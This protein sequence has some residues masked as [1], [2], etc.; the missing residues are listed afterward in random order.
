MFLTVEEAAQLAGLSH[1]TIRM[2]QRKGRLKR[3][4]VGSRTVVSRTELLELVKPTRVKDQTMKTDI[5]SGV[6]HAGRRCAYPV[7][8]QYV[9]HYCRALALRVLPR[10]KGVL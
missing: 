7:P 2:W 1:W 9:K 8:G 3:Y 5:L 4:K 10:Y 6:Q